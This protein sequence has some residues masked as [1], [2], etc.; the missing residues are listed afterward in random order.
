VGAETQPVM[1]ELGYLGQVIVVLLAA[2]VFVVAFKSAGLGAILGYLAAG[3]V[4]GPAGLNFITDVHAV[5]A[6]AELGVVFL[7]FMVGLELPLERI[8]VTFGPIFALGAAQV[9]ATAAVI[10]GVALLFGLPGAAAA[11]VGGGL[12]LSSTAIV[13]RLL[14]D[15]GGISSR[16]GRTAFG[17]LLVQDIAV[18]PFLVIAVALGHQ[19][20]GQEVGLGEALGL[21]ALKVTVALLAIL[22]L[23]RIVLRHVFWPVAAVREPEVF[24]AMTLLVVLCTAI[25]TKLAGLSLGFG[26]FL[27]G[28]LLAETHYRHQVAAV[29]QPFRAL[30]LGLFFMTVGMSLEPEPIVDGAYVIV[31]LLAA[32]L[33][34][35][36]A[37]LAGLARAFKLPW[38]QALH[39]G[40]LLA[41]GGEFAFVLF[42]AALATGLLAPEIGQLLVVVTGLSMVATPWLARL[43]RR[44][45]RRVERA[46]LGGVDSIAQDTVALSD[47]VVI[48][49]FGRVGRA[50]ADGLIAAGV[51]FAAADLDPHRVAQARQRGLPV[52]YGDATEPEVLEALHVER[53]QTF[54]VAIDDPKAALQAVAL[55]TYIFPELDVFARAQD[56]EHGAELTRL[57][58]ELV[59]PELAPT[60]R[61]L[62]GS[63]LEARAAKAAK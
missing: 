23:G 32:L 30:L 40:I 31:P 34:A 52:F 56:D 25:A 5:G 26:A 29:I 41:Q 24:A 35:K 51:P 20:A 53:A 58:A 18:G 61:Q 46:G 19:A 57:G 22:G 4:I 6:L 28:M 13:I 62:A 55:I 3:A 1:E 33:L 63:I 14:A 59:V 16:F 48:A 44:V 9:L 60:G 15:A 38:A 37:L 36:A 45:E 39:L 12:A 42:G 49:G 8:R 17:V 50:V 21:A 7:L 43:G 2:V 10:A 54:V 11:V 47:H 27:A